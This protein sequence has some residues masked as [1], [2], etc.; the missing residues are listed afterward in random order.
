MTELLRKAFDEARKLPDREQDAIA[1]RM[2][3]EIESER[4]WDRAFA[5][6]GDLLSR[7]ADEALEEHKAGLTQALDPD[8][9]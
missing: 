9:I 7:L 1:S 4:H 2:L 8:Q 5:R 6:S 3:V